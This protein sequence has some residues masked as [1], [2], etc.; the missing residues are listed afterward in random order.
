[1][2]MFIDHFCGPFLSNT[3]VK[4]AVVIVFGV[5]FIELLTSGITTTR[6]GLRTSDIALYNT[7]Q[8]A[9]ALLTE[10]NISIQEA[11]LITRAS[12]RTFS[13]PLA[14]QQIL[15]SLDTLEQSPWIVQW[16]HM[17]DV[18][19]LS[20]GLSSFLMA[21]SA[22]QASGALSPCPAATS[23]SPV[24]SETCLSS[25]FCNFW[26]S[27]SGQ[28]C[29]PRLSCH[30]TTHRVSCNTLSSFMVTTRTSFYFD[31]LMEHGGR[32]SAIN[33]VQ[34]RVDPYSDDNVE[35]FL[36]GYAFYFWEQYIDIEV[37]LIAVR[38][39]MSCFSV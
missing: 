22:S 11:N 26:R 8:H 15:D 32:L 19:F 9:L 13:N 7:C 37:T 5:F 17:H 12:S 28:F 23:I 34:P 36:I 39:N 6:Q 29:S 33:D 1:M 30:N 16:M 20:S 18:N 31:N 14:Q 3:I 24:Q 27:F 4:V 10:N 2:S 35:S 25:Y 21:Y 38:I